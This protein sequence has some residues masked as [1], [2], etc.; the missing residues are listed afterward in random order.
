MVRGKQRKVW[1]MAS[2][3]LTGGRPDTSCLVFST[4]SSLGSYMLLRAAK[5][6][7]SSRN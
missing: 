5:S 4:N 6:V 3:N 7:S 2:S 1:L